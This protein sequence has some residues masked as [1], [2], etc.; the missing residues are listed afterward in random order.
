M[1]KGR[2]FFVPLTSAW[3]YNELSLIDDK[4]ELAAA[5][6]YGPNPSRGE[7]RICAD[8]ILRHLPELF[9]F[10]PDGPKKAKDIERLLEQHKVR[11]EDGE[12]RVLL[13]ASA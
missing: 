8:V 3:Q 7:C 6:L 9:G 11:I 4:A 1:G 13:D 10:A 12:G 5:L 2:S